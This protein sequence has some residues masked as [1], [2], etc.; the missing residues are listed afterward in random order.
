MPAKKTI[1]GSIDPE[2]LTFTVGKD[3]VL[4]LALAEAD[5]LGTAAH[6]TML[7]RLDVKPKIFNLSEKKKIIGELVSM[8]AEVRTGVFK[9]GSRD[10]DIHLAIEAALTKQFG[11]IGKKVHTARSRNDQVAVD[12]RLYG[13]EQLLQA[14]NEVVI[15]AGELLR[16]AFKHAAVPMVG[17]THCLPAMPSSVGLW[18]SAH[19]ES[20]LDDIILLTGAYDFNDR[21]PLGSAAGY[22]VSLEIDRQLTSK[23]LGFKEPIHNVLYASNA[24]GKCE[25][26]ILSAMGQ[27]MISLSRIAADLIMYSMPEMGYFVLPPDYCTG[28]SI[29]PQKNNPDVFELVRARSSSVLGCAS[30][31][32]GIVNALPSGYNRDMQETKEPFIEGIHTTRSCLRVMASAIKK[33]KVDEK[34]LVAG[35]SPEVFAADRALEL[36][37]GGMTFRD[38]YDAVKKDLK[39]L[40]K[41]DPKKAIA[42][43]QH[44]G[45]PG[46]LDFDELAKRV[47]EGKR[48]FTRE[49]RRY[50]GAISKLIGVKY[51]E[52]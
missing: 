37:V 46:G 36:T 30:T 29:M 49:S 2:V 7:S 31:V 1:V 43:K 8:I 50:H 41:K 14:I 27:V 16:F 52:L 11:D 18:A 42:E 3:M 45:A 24:R 20:L 15:L 47:T 21:C 6:V 33:I 34:A 25:S 44:L 28:S 12:L 10:Q 48:F 35:F 32:S 13:K 38:A 26:V 9:I 51:P 22:G 4:D 40:K 17:R 19:A 5:C 39:E 23:L